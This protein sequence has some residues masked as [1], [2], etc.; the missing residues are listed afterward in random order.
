MLLRELLDACVQVA[1]PLADPL[2]RAL[3]GFLGRVAEQGSA[4]SI[5]RSKASR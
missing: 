4:A 1:L 3:G 2:A 5:A